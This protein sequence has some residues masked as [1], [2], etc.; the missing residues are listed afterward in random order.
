M[1]EIGEMNIFSVRK[2]RTEKIALKLGQAVK[3]AICM[4]YM[5]LSLFIWRAPPFIL[6]PDCLW[7]MKLTHSPYLHTHFPAIVFAAKMHHFFHSRWISAL[8]LSGTVERCKRTKHDTAL[9]FPLNSVENTSEMHKKRYTLVKTMAGAEKTHVWNDSKHLKHTTRI[10]LSTRWKWN[11]LW[12]IGD[13]EHH[14]DSAK[15][16]RHEVSHSTKKNSFYCVPYVF[17]ICRMNGVHMDLV[18]FPHQQESTL[19]LVDC[20]LFNHFVTSLLSPNVVMHYTVVKK[21]LQ[22]SGETENGG[23]T[24]LASWWLQ[25]WSLHL[26]AECGGKKPALSTEVQSTSIRAVTVFNHE[27]KTTLATRYR[28]LL[29][30]VFDTR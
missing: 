10:K 27:C 20:R 5:T 25:Q 12:M 2:T 29:C 24:A 7:W 18:G 21:K 15:N 28:C 14:N 1:T 23:R 30:C 16:S 22:C 19:N 17:I 4:A 11:E 9:T 3:L 13:V 8:F 26:A 6:R